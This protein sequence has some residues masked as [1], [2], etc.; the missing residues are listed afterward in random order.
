MAQSG[1]TPIQVYRSTTASEV[2]AAGNLVAGEPAINTVDMKLF[3]KN[4]SGVVQALMNNPAALVYPTAD[5]TANQ[6]VITNGLGSLTFADAVMKT[7]DTGSAV[8]PTGTTAERDGS[9]QEGYV[10]FNT[11]DGVVETYDGSNWGA[12]GATSATQVSYDNSAS[13][14]T[15]TDVQDAI[16]EVVDEKQDT[17]V[18]GVNIKTV[19]ST[20]LLGSGDLLIQGVPTGAVSYFSSSSAP[21][22]WLKSNGAAISRTTYSALFAAIGT[23]FGAGDGSTTFNVPD[24]RGEFMRGWDDGRGVDSGRGFGTAQADAFQG[25]RHRILLYP[26]SAVVGPKSGDNTPQYQVDDGVLDPI[27]DGVNGTPRTA[28]E[29]RPRNIALLACIK[30]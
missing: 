6:V 20:S 5:G 25:H 22:G 8:M 15:A 27:T 3:F 16:D 30:Y 17:L 7:S 10:R 21:T 29:T 12:V 2:P 1:Y 9:P 13:G 14:L 24:L 11:D 26:G 4:A 28:A 23:T 19:N 18:S